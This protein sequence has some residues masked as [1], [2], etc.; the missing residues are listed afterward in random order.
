LKVILQNRASIASNYDRAAFF[1]Q[2]G[3]RE[4]WDRPTY[5][6]KLKLSMPNS[7]DNVGIR[8]TLEANPDL[9]GNP[10]ALQQIIRTLLENIK[11]KSD[12]LSQAKP[13]ANMPVKALPLP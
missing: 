9:D 8:S 4:N 12:R 1:L 2:V 6:E 10:K 3:L 13:S 5:L 7:G 11:Q